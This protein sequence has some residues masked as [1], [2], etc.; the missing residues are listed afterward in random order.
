MSKNKMTAVEWLVEQSK[1]FHNKESMDKLIE[2]AKRLEREQIEEAYYSNKCYY[3]RDNSIDDYYTQ[4][5]GKC[6]PQS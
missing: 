2:A 4:T 3:C 5:Y 1:G 6:T